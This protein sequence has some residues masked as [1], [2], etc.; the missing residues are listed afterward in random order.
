MYETQR[1]T[2]TRKNIERL[3]HNNSTPRYILGLDL[4]QSNDYTALAVIERVNIYADEYADRKEITGTAFHLHHLHRFPLT[5]IYPAI[6]QEVAA[7]MRQPHIAN[8]CKLVVMDL[9]Q[10]TT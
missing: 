2:V 8:D 4:G 7:I 3:S 10:R 9:Q 5:T 1:S 6:V